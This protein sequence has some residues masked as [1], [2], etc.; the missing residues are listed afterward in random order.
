MKVI[1][2]YLHEN[3]PEDKAFGVQL[4]YNHHETSDALTDE[5]VKEVLTF[6][7]QCFIES[8]MPLSHL[9]KLIMSIPVVTIYL[10][11]AVMSKRST[12][13]KDNKGKE[14]KEGDILNMLTKNSMSTVIVRHEKDGW[15]GE[16]LFTKHP[17]SAYQESIDFI[18]WEIDGNIYDMAK[19]N[20]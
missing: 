12:W 13:L 3:Y 1:K 2:N 10:P 18:E 8:L 9:S 14:I 16:G 11:E 6:N 17:L 15:F 20:S 5:D 19:T 4:Q 7:E